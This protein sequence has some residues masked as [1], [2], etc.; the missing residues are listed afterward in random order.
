MDTL[1]VRFKLPKWVVIF[2][3]AWRYLSGLAKG[4]VTQQ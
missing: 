4:F 1:A 2:G 3:W